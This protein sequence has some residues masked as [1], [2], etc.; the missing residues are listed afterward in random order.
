VPL[1]ETA[2]KQDIEYMR[3]HRHSLAERLQATANSDNRV[4]RLGNYCK[5]AKR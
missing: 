2:L 3:V 1:N 4:A 5:A